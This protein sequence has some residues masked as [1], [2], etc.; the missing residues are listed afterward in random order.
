MGDR[1]IQDVECPY[2]HTVNKGV[3]YADGWG[4]FMRCEKCHERSNLVFSFVINAVKP[5]SKT[6]KSVKL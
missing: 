5:S 3:L 2:C 4:E 6:N 1:Y